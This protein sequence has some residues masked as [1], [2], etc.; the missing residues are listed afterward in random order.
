MAGRGDDDCGGV[1]DSAGGAGGSAAV[2]CLPDYE[3]LG[4]D[5]ADYGTVGALAAVAA[6]VMNDAD[7]SVRAPFFGVIWY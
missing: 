7:R 2:L 4:A 3:P 6:G 5:A 1:A